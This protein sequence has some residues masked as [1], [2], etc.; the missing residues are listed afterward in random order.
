MFRFEKSPAKTVEFD[1]SHPPSHS[2]RIA[3]IDDDDD[4]DGDDGDESDEGEESDES[5]DDRRKFRSQ[6]SDSMDR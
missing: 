6:T 3:A 4:D 1:A 5:N 2:N